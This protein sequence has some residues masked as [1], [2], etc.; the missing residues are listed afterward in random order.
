MEKK[1]F[2]NWL[3]KRK[4]PDVEKPI[5]NNQKQEPEFKEIQEERI[6]KPKDPIK[7]YNETLYSKGSAL[8]HPTKASPEKKQPAT[9]TS[10][11]NAEIIE[12]NIDKMRRK[13]SEPTDQCTQRKQDTDKKVDYI[14]LKKK[15]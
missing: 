1:K 11:E 14:L 3:K 12:E 5:V 2:V 6:E 7:E 15:R 9:R 4:Q 8:K 13:H 10:W